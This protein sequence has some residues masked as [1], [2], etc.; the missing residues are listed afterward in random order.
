MEWYT[1]IIDASA[2]IG[3]VGATLVA[4]WL[5]FRDHRRAVDSVFIWDAATLYQPTLLIQNTSSRMVVI[6]SITIKYCNKTIGRT[7]VL[8]SHKMAEY[9]V[10]NAGQDIKIPPDRLNISLPNF[11]KKRQGDEYFQKYRKKK[12]KLKV[13]IRLRNG[14]KNTSFVKYSYGELS[15]C[16]IGQYFFSEE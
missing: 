7:E 9:A 10:V 11:K 15:E 4:L 1:L 12:H 16:A 5:A 6:D 2:A 8:N 13:I 3:T 14:R